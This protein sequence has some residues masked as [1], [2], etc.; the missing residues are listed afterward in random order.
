[1]LDR[2]DDEFP[3]PVL[4]GLVAGTLTPDELKALD[5]RTFEVTGK[6]FAELN[7]MPRLMRYPQWEQLLALDFDRYEKT[8][9][10]EPLD[11]AGQEMRDRLLK[12]LFCPFADI[13]GPCV[14]GK[15]HAAPSGMDP[16]IAAGLAEQL[17]RQCEQLC[18][19]CN[20]PV[21]AG[22]CPDGADCT[23][24]CRNAGMCIGDGPP[25]PDNEPDRPPGCEWCGGKGCRF[26]DGTTPPADTTAPPRVRGDLQ[27]KPGPSVFD[28]SQVSMIIEGLREEMQQHDRRLQAVEAWYRRE[29]GHPL[30][31]HEGK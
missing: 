15:T 31:R 2:N 8:C 5:E 22:R 1:M 7:G 16:V 12:K 4:D 30:P 20:L 29:K 3:I 14:C 24:H 11:A 17:A 18:D 9:H 19:G 21:A 27:L 25:D 26:C 6:S 13:P 28:A 10:D 23:K